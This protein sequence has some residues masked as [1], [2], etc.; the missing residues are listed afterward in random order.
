MELHELSFG[1]III[2]REDIAE[3][4]INEGV[5]MNISMVKE[6]HQF[7][8]TH[9]KSPFSL[10][11]NKVNFY[12]Y[13]FEA[14]VNIATL[15]EINAMAVVAYKR[16]TSISTESLVSMPRPVEWNLK[17]FPNRSD[18]FDWLL[19]EQNLAHQ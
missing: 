10:L 4:I 11:V 16:N 6:Y 13:D 9:L 14:Q 2:L 12:T 19:N 18:A 17:I 5:E 15:N 8:L 7:L 3:V 1:K